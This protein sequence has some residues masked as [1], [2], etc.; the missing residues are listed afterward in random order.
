MLPRLLIFTTL[1]AA[2]QGSSVEWCDYWRLRGVA[3]PECQQLQWSVQRDFNRPHPAAVDTYAS[4]IPLCHVVTSMSQCARTGF[5]GSGLICWVG[6]QPCCANAKLNRQVGAPGISNGGQCPAAE[7]L[8]VV[9]RQKKAISWCNYDRDCHMTSSMHK[10]CPTAC[11][12]NMCIPARQ[13]VDLIS[14]MASSVAVPD[15][16]PQLDDIPIW[17][18]TP[19]NSGVSWCTKHS[20]CRQTAVHTRVCCPTR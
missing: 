1:Y 20:E 7:D 14:R 9:C 10:C 8:Q 2:V 19:L 17:C 12:Y 13:P 3:R 4:S 5:C 6:G 11:G 15:Q 18:R 16:C